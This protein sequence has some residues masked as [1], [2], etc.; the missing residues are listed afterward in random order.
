MNGMNNIYTHCFLLDVIAYP[1]PN[2]NDSLVKPL[3]MIGMGE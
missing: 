3:L 1:C 2:F